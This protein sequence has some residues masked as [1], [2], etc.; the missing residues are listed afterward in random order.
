MQQ[1]MKRLTNYLIIGLIISFFTT[2]DKYEIKDSWPI[3]SCIVKNRMSQPVTIKWYNVVKEDSVVIASNNDYEI[4]EDKYGTWG[5]YCDSVILSTSMQT[6]AYVLFKD[7]LGNMIKSGF[8]DYAPD[9]LDK[10]KNVSFHIYTLTDSSFY[11]F[12][13]ECAKLGQDI[14]RKK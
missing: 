4:S 7:S 8:I 12:A 3:Y 11:K 13:H 9:S 2:C 1:K 5:L 14:W 6:V 10:I